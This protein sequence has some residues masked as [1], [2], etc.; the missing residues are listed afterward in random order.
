[1]EADVAGLLERIV[2]RSGTGELTPAALMLGTTLVLTLTSPP[3]DRLLTIQ[4]R[5]GDDLVAVL[6]DGLFDGDLSQLSMT[7]LLSPVAHDTLIHPD[8]GGTR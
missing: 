4:P 1:M 3:S 8:P 7:L 2:F 5:Q 6:T